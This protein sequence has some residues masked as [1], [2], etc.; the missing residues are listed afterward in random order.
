MR[1]YE[2]F[3]Q[4]STTSESSQCQFNFKRVTRCFAARIQFVKCSVTAVRGLFWLSFDRY[5]HGKVLYKKIQAFSVLSKTFWAHT[6]Q[7]FTESATHFSRVGQQKSFF[8]STVVFGKPGWPV[9]SQEWIRW[10]KCRFA[11]SRSV[12]PFNKEQTK[13]N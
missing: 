4:W 9:L 7:L 5:V 6:W 3:F 2:L 13:W 8:T 11:S 10:I 12:V 1:N